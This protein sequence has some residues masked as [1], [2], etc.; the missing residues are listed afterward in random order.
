MLTATVENRVFEPHGPETTDDGGVP[1]AHPTRDRLRLRSHRRKVLLVATALPP[2]AVVINKRAALE[3]AV[4]V[5]GR[6]DWVWIPLGLTFE[7]ISFTMIARGQRRLFGGRSIRSRLGPFVRTVFVSNALSS[8]IP[9]AGPQAGALYSF[10]RFRRL[11][12]DPVTAGWVLTAS[13]TISSLSAAL[14]LLLGALLSGN[15]AAGVGAVSGGVVSAVVL[16]LALAARG[17]AGRDRVGY[18]AVAVLR[19]ARRLVGRPKTDPS[20]L[21]GRVARTLETMRLSPKDWAFVSA[22][23]SLN[24]LADIAVLAVSISAV[25]ASVPWR[26]LLLAYG[27][28]EAAGVVVL[29]PGGV[30]VVEAAMAGSLMASGVHHSAALAAVLLYRLISFWLVAV[31]GWL[32]YIRDLRALQRQAALT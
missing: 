5:L 30:G 12:A 16:G 29:T 19:G 6:L 32:M 1:P 28:G 9:L 3:M 11:G 13:G 25:G 10:R 26:G 7:A 17:A 21:V 18:I 8:S 14:L 23:A 15:R 31:A 24:W 2:V 4:G 22:E 20:V 27:I